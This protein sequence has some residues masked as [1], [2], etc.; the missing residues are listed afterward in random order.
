MNST[1]NV[2]ERLLTL[3]AGQLRGIS[4]TILCFCMVPEED[5]EL[6]KKERGVSLVVINEGGF[7]FTRQW[8]AFG[9]NEGWCRKG[10]L[11]VDWPSGKKIQCVRKVVCAIFIRIKEQVCGG[12][13]PGGKLTMGF[14]SCALL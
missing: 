14:L 1:G 7:I 4:P 12:W 6:V 10:T 9:G 8:S 13:T 2:G 5:A 11:V 3:C